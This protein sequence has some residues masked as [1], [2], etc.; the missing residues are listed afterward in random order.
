MVSVMA[1]VVKGMTSFSSP[2]YT[3]MPRDRAV[4]CSLN[5]RAFLTERKVYL[6]VPFSL[7]CILGIVDFISDQH[8]FQKEM[9]TRL[10]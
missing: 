6:P 8:L 2:S 9:N 4:C 7:I 5:K 1:A 3:T 10:K